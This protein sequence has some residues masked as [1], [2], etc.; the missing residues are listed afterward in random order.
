MKK[1]LTSISI[2]LLMI[3][4]MFISPVKGASASSSLTGPSTVRA[5]DTITLNF[6]ITG[7]DVYGVSGSLSYDSSKVSLV[8][9]KKQI[10]SSW[11]VEFNGNSFVAYDNTLTAPINNT[12]TIFTATFKVKN[13]NEGALVNIGVKGITAT[14]GNNDI[15]AGSVSYS[16][17]IVAPLSSDNTLSSLTVSNAKISPE[18]SSSVTSYTASVPFEI[19]KLSI[20]AIPSDSKASVSISNNKL[21]DNAIT[22]VAVIVKAENGNK[23]TYTI[24]VKRDA[25]PNYVPSSNNN[26]SSLKVDGYVLSPKFSEDVNNYIVWLPY[27]T[28]SINVS[29]VCENEKASINVEGGETLEAGQDNKIKVVVKAENG[30]E[31]EYIIT[32]KRAHPH[33]QEDSNQEGLITENL[34]TESG[35]LKVVYYILVFVL[36]IVVGV[37]LHKIL[38]K[39]KKV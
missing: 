4:T 29:G 37:I 35:S 6:K 12:K 31:K 38:I 28:E 16:K 21:K 14:D 36:G 15:N 9:T 23:K 39:N 24:S 19:E 25:D 11:A 26:L 22:K 18:F 1:I 5:N 33:I 30:D 13:L 3:M 32:A 17:K 34:E 20:K 2:C 8:S 7:K 10:G 27:E